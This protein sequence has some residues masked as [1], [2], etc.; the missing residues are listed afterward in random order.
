MKTSGVNSDTWIN[1]DIHLLSVTEGNVEKTWKLT[2]LHVDY[3]FL[4]E[5]LCSYNVKI[6]DVRATSCKYFHQ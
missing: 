2:E 5:L 6:K 3:F 4:M 1:D